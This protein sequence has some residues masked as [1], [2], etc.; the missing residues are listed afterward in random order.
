MYQTWGVSTPALLV[1]LVHWASYCGNDFDKSRC[2]GLLKGVLQRLPS[3]FSIGLDAGTL[4]SPL[5]PPDPP[6]N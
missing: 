6:P 5:R 1:I 3:Q 4:A 2:R